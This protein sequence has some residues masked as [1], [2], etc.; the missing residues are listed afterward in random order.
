METNSQRLLKLDE[1]N[2]DGKLDIR[3][4]HQIV[5]GKPTDHA[6]QVMIMVDESFDINAIYLNPSPRNLYV[7]FNRTSSLSSCFGLTK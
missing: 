4:M 2:S 6:G 7:T 1:S 5:A 3:R